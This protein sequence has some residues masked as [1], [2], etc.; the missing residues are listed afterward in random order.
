MF[1]T[2]L[3]ELNK[4]LKEISSFAC[5]LKTRNK[6]MELSPT[7]DEDII[8]NSL[9]ETY[10]AKNACLRLGL[11]ELMPYD[12]TFTLDRIRINSMINANEFKEIISLIYN[13]NKFI[14]YLKKC[15][16][17]GVELEYLNRYYGAL[18]SLDPLKELIDNVFD[19][20]LNIKDTASSNLYKIRREIRRLESEVSSKFNQY[21]KL[22]QSALSES[23]VT[24]RNGHKVIPVKNEYKSQIKGIIYDESSSGQTV[25]IEPKEV[26]EIEAKIQ[27]LTSEEN[28]EIE[29]ILFSL[30]NET[31]PYYE[32]LRLDDD[33]ILTLDFIFAKALYARE[34]DG[35]LPTISDSLLYLDARHPL[36]DKESC[37]PNTIDFNNKKAMIITGPNTGGKTVVL[38]TLG[39]LS[40]MVQSGILIPVKEGSKAQIFTGIYAD[41]GDEQSIEQSL[42]T[43][44]S[45]MKRIVKITKDAEKNS[46]VLLDE[47]GSG[48]DPK[49]GASL[50]ISILNY[51]RSKDLFIASTTHYPELKLYAYSNDDILNA[52]V[53][54]DVNSLKPTYKLILGISGKSNAFLISS[55]LGLSD[56][57]IN[58]AK[59]LS[60]EFKDQESILINR[61]ENETKRLK[62]EKE[63]YQSLNNSLKEEI[64]NTQKEALENKKAYQEK[65]LE[66]EEKREEILLKTEK[67]AT[68]LLDEIKELKKKTN[69][70]IVKETKLAE[71]RGKTN[72]L[73]KPG[74]KKKSFSNKEIK[75]GDSVKVLEY[76]KIGVVLSIR[77]NNYTVALGPLNSTFKKTEIELVQVND[78]YKKALNEYKSEKSIVRTDIKNRLDLRGYRYE[79]A[80]EA[81]EKFIDDSI[82]INLE[83]VEVIHG[84]G[85]LALRNMVLKYCETNKNIK[86]FRPGNEQE[87]SKGVTIITLR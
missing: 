51:L 34:I 73:I 46:L 39:L 74:E 63:K 27:I 11:I 10:E 7:V 41:I 18:D 5:N 31:F 8:V 13:V 43:F 48:T 82:Y 53:E 1:E 79:D 83:T 35:E 26:A 75:V 77:N 30:S 64:R 85:T 72:S 44:S 20:E 70:E 71:L 55:R 6:I 57:I 24:L 66:L 14:S 16:N 28:K 23:L 58:E 36:I 25:Y 59:D 42:S 56:E 61:L 78:E 4:I 49:E 19:D 15:E 45:H 22:Y 60:L 62:H 32:A 38:K 29:K 65:L 86:S 37:V 50:A 84:Y 2:K 21:L 52:S 9:R 87:G 69:S 3:L 54:F 67:E 17:L 40:L 47:L 68:L 33:T 12:L 80:K 76:D 81:L